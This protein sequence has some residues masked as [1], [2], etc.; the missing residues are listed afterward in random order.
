MRT[1]LHGYVTSRLCSVKF[2]VY[3]EFQTTAE[4]LGTVHRISI[5]I[6]FLFARH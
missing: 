2:I 3:E 1:T 6:E 5:F 4:A